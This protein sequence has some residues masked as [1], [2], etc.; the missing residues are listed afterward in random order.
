MSDTETTT[1]DYEITYLLEEEDAASVRDLLSTRGGVIT[2]ERPL[3]K[4][5]LSYPIAGRA[6]AFLGVTVFQAAPDSIAVLRSD[7]R[8]AGR[9]LRSLILSY[10]PHPLQETS[11]S[12]SYSSS[13]GVGGADRLVSSDTSSPAPKKQETPRHGGVVTSQGLTNEALEKTIEEILK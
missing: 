1:R 13:F 10:V 2:E 6:Q 4:V 7:L 3:T 5:Q 12:P 8:L 9:V 11:S